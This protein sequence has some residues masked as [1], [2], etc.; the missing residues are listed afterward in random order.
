MDIQNLI[1]S[2]LN[3]QVIGQM[4]KS[5]GVDDSKVSSVISMAV[6]A[7]L[8][9]MNKNAQT[10]QGA[11]S[12]NNALKDHSGSILDNLGG[13]LGGG[14]TNNAEGESILNHIFGGKQEQLAQNLGA[15]AGLSSGNT[16]QILSSIAPLIM[17]FL[18]KEKQQGNLNASNLTGVLGNLFSS[19]TQGGDKNMVEKL[20]DQN[21]DGSITD[22]L[23]NM[24]SNLLKGFFKK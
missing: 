19:A 3:N 21:G 16:M 22:D 2:A 9:Q 14:T 17:G 10:P 13:L 7:I 1:T 18:G 4:S 12:L 20:L 15:Q 11:E 5:L 24:G 23:M 8:G 6:P